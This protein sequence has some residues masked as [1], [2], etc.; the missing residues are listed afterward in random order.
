MGREWIPEGYNVFGAHSRLRQWLRAEFGC[1]WATLRVAAGRQVGAAQIGK[2]TG[3]SRKVVETCGGVRSRG[4][5]FDG[6][7]M[8]W[9]RAQIRGRGI[10][11]DVAGMH[12]H[13]APGPLAGKR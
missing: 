4:D 11:D 9:F 8:A 12:D 13:D 7:R 3:N 5:Q 6:V 10:L 1:A 2:R